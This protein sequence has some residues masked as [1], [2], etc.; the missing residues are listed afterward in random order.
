MVGAED[1]DEFLA[2]QRAISELFAEV[3]AVILDADV[4]EVDEPGL[5]PGDRGSARGADPRVAPPDAPGHYA[6]PRAIL[7]R[8]LKRIV[9]NL[10]G[11]ANTVSDPSYILNVSGD[12]PED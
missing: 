1:L 3:S 10:V 12:D 2:A 8:Y 6:V 11:V 7:H 5:G 9:A 4:H